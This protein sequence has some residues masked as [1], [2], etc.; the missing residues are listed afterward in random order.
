MPLQTYSFATNPNKY[1]SCSDMVNGECKV[2]KDNDGCDNDQVNRILCQSQLPNQ[3]NNECDDNLVDQTITFDCSAADENNT[4]ACESTIT[5]FN[6]DSSCS[7]I[8]NEHCDQN[9]CTSDECPQ[10]C[11]GGQSCGPG[12][13]DV[14][15]QGNCPELTEWT[16]TTT[17]EKGCEDV[18][19]EQCPNSE[20][21]DFWKYLTECYGSECG[22]KDGV[23]EYCVPRNCEGPWCP[24][25]DK[26]CFNI[27]DETTCKQQQFNYSNS[28]EWYTETTFCGDL[29]SGGTFLHG[30]QDEREN[31]VF[32]PFRP[33]KSPSDTYQDR[34]ERSVHNSTMKGDSGYTN[35]CPWI[36]YEGCTAFKNQGDNEALQYSSMCCEGHCSDT[37]PSGDTDVEQANDFM[38][39]KDKLVR[40]ARSTDAISCSN[41]SFCSWDYTE[42][43]CS[44]TT[45]GPPA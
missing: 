20:P 34:C 33:P 1:K 44:S 31:C 5:V 43:T 32:A 16:G 11:G 41:Y 27:D 15:C 26:T 2:C 45:S 4:Q 23:R 21:E 18:F 9:Q 10:I 7:D 8:I 14:N 12:L 35:G 38:S 28:C 13:V 25:P 42:N 39:D 24:P 6:E 22:T 30:L 29:S 19:T 36:Y 3:I 17:D 37:F 40:C